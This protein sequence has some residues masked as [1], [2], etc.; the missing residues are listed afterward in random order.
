MSD[1]QEILERVAEKLSNYRKLCEKAGHDE[2]AIALFRLEA[3]VNKLTRATKHINFDYVKITD[4]NGDVLTMPSIEE[5][6]VE[7]SHHH[8]ASI[9]EMSRTLDI[10]RTTLYR[11]FPHYCKN[12]KKARKELVCE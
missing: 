8:F 9:A 11:R 1:T 12:F 2:E 6:V 4:D 7:N 3:E 5:L 10:S